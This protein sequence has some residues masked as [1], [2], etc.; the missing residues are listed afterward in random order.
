MVD[1]GIKGE[2][3]GVLVAAAGPGMASYDNK[4]IGNRISGNEMPGV[5]VHS[6]A[7]NQDVSDNLIAGNDIGRNNLGGD[8]DAN[9]KETTGILVFSAVVP[10]TEKVRDNHIHDNQIPIWTSPN[11]TLN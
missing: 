11:V 2:G 8:P 5:T 10:T 6:H 3:A 1:N 7:P 9:V 4:I